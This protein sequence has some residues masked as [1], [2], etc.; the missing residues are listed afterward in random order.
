MIRA[1]IAVLVIET[2]GDYLSFFLTIHR[3]YSL[4]CMLFAVYVN[5]TTPMVMYMAVLMDMVM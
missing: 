4:F 2:R 5:A 3:S 1:A